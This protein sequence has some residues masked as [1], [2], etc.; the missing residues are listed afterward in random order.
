MTLLVYVS[1]PQVVIDPA[2]PVPEWRLTREGHSRVEAV[3]GQPWVTRLQA[4]ATSPERKARE[5]AE[6]LGRVSCAPVSVL[7]TSGEIDRSSTGYVPHVEHE[8]L[9][10]LLFARPGQSASGWERAVD[11]RARIMQAAKALLDANS[12]KAAIAMVGHGGIGTL[13]ARGLSGDGY[14]RAHDQPMGGCAF[15]FDSKTETILFHWTP[16][17]RVHHHLP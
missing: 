15:A 2:V 3:A 11:A 5:T 6:L 4:I 9:A 1:H 12:D 10:D 14:D 7:D 13:L 17:E 16:L 8:R